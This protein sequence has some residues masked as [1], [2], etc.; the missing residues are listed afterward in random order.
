[1]HINFSEI[2]FHTV[3]SP[4]LIVLVFATFLTSFEADIFEVIAL[5][6]F[7]WKLRVHV[8]TTYVFTRAVTFTKT[9]MCSNF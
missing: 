6:I 1:M 8:C 7:N 9:I 4:F 2:L 5:Y 3:S